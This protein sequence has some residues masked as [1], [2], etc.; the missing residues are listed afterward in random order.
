MPVRLRVFGVFALGIAGISFA[1]LF[2][3]WALPAPPVVTGFYRMLFA[4]LLLGGWLAARGGGTTMEPRS[5]A[6]ALAGGACFGTDLALWNTAIVRTSLANA[7]FLVNTTP[8]YVGL[9][10]VALLGERLSPRFVLGSGLALAGT[11]ALVRADWGG[12]EAVRGDV[13]ALGAGL[14]Y[15]GH[16]LLMKAVRRS[17]ATVP[18]LAVAGVGATLVLGVYGLVGRDAFAGFPA[19]SWWAFAGAAVVSQIGGVMG[20]VWSLRY[21]RASFASVAL[22][23]QPVGTAL[24]GWWLLGEALGPLQLAGSAAVGAGILL[25]S[26]AARDPAAHEKERS[27]HQG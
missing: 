2:V 26:G 24:L 20:V 15:A 4:T 1:A 25:A 3:R 10:S 17:M 22:L 27:S 9:V 13:L 5:V 23:A 7:T 18:A 12:A 21:L 16:L 14:F 8:I 6:L 19:S 11:A